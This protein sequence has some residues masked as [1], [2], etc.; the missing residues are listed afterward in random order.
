VGSPRWTDDTGYTA[1][2]NFGR[3]CGLKGLSGTTVEHLWTTYGLRAASVIDIAVE[4][5]R[6]GLWSNLPASVG[7]SDEGSKTST[8]TQAKKSSSWWS[9]SPKSNTTAPSSSSLNQTVP[10]YTKDA[11]F[12]FLLPQYPILSAE[13]T[14]AARYELCETASDFLCRRTRLAFV[15][16]QAA[17]DAVPKVIAILA[18]EHKWSPAQA[19]AE[20]A[21]ARK[22]LSTFLPPKPV[23]PVAAA[24]LRRAN[25]PAVDPVSV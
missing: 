7:S 25:A 15:D 19:T 5:E 22:H 12:D 16:A 17:L 8:A 13:V 10:R 21:A 4:A 11:G 14:Y 24:I 9:S 20:A 3:R 2:A 6:V 1:A 18:A 23:V